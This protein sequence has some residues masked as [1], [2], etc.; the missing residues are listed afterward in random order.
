MSALHGWTKSTICE[1]P[2]CKSKADYGYME[3]ATCDNGE[4]LMDVALCRIHANVT[5][6]YNDDKE[7]W[8]WNKLTKKE[9]R[10]VSQIGVSTLQSNQRMMAIKSKYEEI[11]CDH[12]H[13]KVGEVV[14]MEITTKLNCI[15]A[16]ATAHRKANP[17]HTEYTCRVT[18]DLSK[19]E[20]GPRNID[21]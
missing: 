14:D 15:D 7:D 6:N 13:E 5:L 12:C 20:P 18:I 1:Y 3:V 2:R 8:E 21:S 4:D 19:R 17:T 11:F 16:F 10:R 9:K